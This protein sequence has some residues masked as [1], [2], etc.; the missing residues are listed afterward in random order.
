M[1]R[2]IP[3]P[4]TF[5]KMKSMATTILMRV[6]TQEWPRL[7]GSV[8]EEMV[9]IEVNLLLL[10]LP[11]RDHGKRSLVIIIFLVLRQTRRMDMEKK[12]PA[13]EGNILFMQI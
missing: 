6:E 7:I 3:Q 2:R 10:F 5:T 1:K 11:R 8:L 9:G 4:N 12:P 13:V